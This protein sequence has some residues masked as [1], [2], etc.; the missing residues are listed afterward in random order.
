MAFQVSPGVNITEKDLTNVIPA[1]ATTN[2]GVAG[3]FKWGPVGK[4]ITVD[5]EQNLVD[6]FGE[7][8]TDNTYAEYFWTAAN[9]LG[10]GNNLQVVRVAETGAYNAQST[11]TTQAQVKN[12]DD[13]DDGVPAGFNHDHWIA[14]Y[15]G[16]L[17]NS[18]Q[19]KIYDG[20]SKI[21]SGVTASSGYTGDAGSRGTEYTG[22]TGGGAPLAGDDRVVVWSLGTAIEKGDT[23]VFTGGQ[24]RTVRTAASAGT[25]VGVYFDPPLEADLDAGH[26]LSVKTKHM[27]QT[28][29]AGDASTTSWA[30]DIGAS[31]DELHVLVV[32]ED[33]EWTGVSGS[34]LEKFESLSYAGNAK[35]ANGANN[36]YKDVVNEQSRYVWA[37]NVLKNAG[38]GST[39]G[40]Y[41]AS[42]TTWG[43]GNT[44]SFSLSNGADG[45]IASNEA[46]LFVQG[47]SEFQDSET[48]DCSLILGGPAEGTVGKLLVDLCDKRKDCMVFL[49]PPRAAVVNQTASAA[50]GNVRDYRLGLNAENGGINYSSNNLNKASSYAV[51][52]SGWKYQYDKYNDRYM[53]I[54]LN[55]DIAGL[56]AKTELEY[57]AWFPPAG[58]TRGQIRGVVRL[59]YNPRQA[60]RDNLYQD[61]VNPVVSFPGEGTVLFGDKTM[62]TKPSAFDRINVRRLFIILEKAIATAAKYQ[63]FELNDRFTRA[64][65]KSM[66]EPFLRDIQSRR[67]I[68]DFKV[69]CDDSNN[70][71]SVIDRNEFVC[72]IFV[73][74][75]R[76]INFIQ[77]NFIATRTG[78]DFSEVA[79][80]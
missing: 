41:A 63:L 64:Q 35:D 38:G 14:R 28:I 42:G 2:A 49:S 10:Y 12:K 61:Q 59:A 80:A 46:Q 67:G 69:V 66:V 50:Q 52:D 25:T 7:P 70:P 11:G 78:V 60:H 4:R 30:S 75:A 79:G 3:V 31:G 19:V 72:D 43:A 45:A 23:L 58:F 53:W 56:A 5:S 73:K 48:V 37:N 77:L 22:N 47:Y 20:T 18:L 68:T 13:F 71:G 74:P 65:F 57:D 21:V 6:I 40:A 33:G 32:D 8:T 44:S 62:Q 76:S 27:T 51:L 17:G 15:P 34:V 55:G 1:V 9:Y 29:G 54:P 16:A 26:T 24:D 36:Y 39:V